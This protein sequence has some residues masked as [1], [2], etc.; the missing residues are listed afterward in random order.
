MLS[1]AAG[2]RGRSELSDN[3]AV[4][5]SL[6]DYIPARSGADLLCAST[7]LVASIDAQRFVLAIA[8][9]GHR[10]KLDYIER[11]CAE[12]MDEIGSAD[13]DAL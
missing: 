2:T 13:V 3:L 12:E 10:G 11:L 7:R 5:G 1:D 4:G 6:P 9:D 8:S